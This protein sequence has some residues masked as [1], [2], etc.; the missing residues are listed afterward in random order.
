MVSLTFVF[1]KPVFCGA[2]FCFQLPVICFVRI[3]LRF[4]IVWVFINPFLFFPPFCVAPFLVLVLTFWFLQS[5]A[6]FSF[7]TPI[8]L[9][10]HLGFSPLPFGF[11][12][13]LRPSGPH[14]PLPSR[15]RSDSCRCVFPHPSEFF[16]FGGLSVRVSLALSVCL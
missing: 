3:P 16:Q 2:L 5:I 1:H 9:S 15:T 8:V 7:C 11:P 13:H 10:A 14:L 12:S 4:F 6:V